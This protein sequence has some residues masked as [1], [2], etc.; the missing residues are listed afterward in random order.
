MK[1][2]FKL[3]TLLFINLMLAGCLAQVGCAQRTDS[4]QKETE[5]KD[6]TVRIDTP[7]VLPQTEISSTEDSDVPYV[8]TPPEVVDRMLEM[9]NI[10]KDDV[11]YDLGSGDGRIVIAAAKQHGVRGVGIEIDSARVA[12]ARKNARKAGVA[13]LVE[14]RQKD[15]FKADLSNATAVLIYLLPSVNLKLRPKLFRELPAG[16][17]IVSHDFN[18]GDWEPERTVDM[19][20]DTVYRWT[21]PE[22]KPDHL[23]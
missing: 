15:L 13:D 23:K 2:P 19:G 11:V 5:Q 16:T 17:P 4:T 18:M 6:P 1:T 9:A 12:E 10:S 21:I 14:F 7:Q 22:E 20:D 8:P 3:P